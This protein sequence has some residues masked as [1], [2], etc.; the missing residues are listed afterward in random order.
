MNKDC[1]LI[2]EIINKIEK[3]YNIEKV[4]PYDFRGFSKDCFKELLMI[5][6]K[7]GGDDVRKE[8]AM[9]KLKEL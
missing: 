4:M 2:Q 9:S 1:E 7:Y 5:Y 6:I 8:S 3:G